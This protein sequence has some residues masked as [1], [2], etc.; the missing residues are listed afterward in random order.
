MTVAVR[1]GTTLTVDGFTELW[2]TV[3]VGTSCPVCTTW[4]TVLESVLAAKV[5]SPP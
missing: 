5:A 2:I 1:V 4:S 3:T